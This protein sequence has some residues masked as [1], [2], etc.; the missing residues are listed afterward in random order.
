MFAESALYAQVMHQDPVGKPSFA[1]V[2][3]RVADLIS[4]F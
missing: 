2:D 1:E 4:V 3:K